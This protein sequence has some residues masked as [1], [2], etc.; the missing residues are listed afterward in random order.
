MA[1]EYRVDNPT[2]QM[3]RLSGGWIRL[4]LIRLLGRFGFREETFVILTACGIGLLTGIGSV[5]FTKLIDCAHDLCY[6]E[7]MVAG[8]YRGRAL[9]LILLPACGALL[10]GLITFFFAREARGHGVP[11]VMDA[12]ARRD[13]VIRPRVAVAKAISSALTIGSGGSAGT[14][15]PIIQ[16]GSAIGSASG[17]FFRVPG[18]HLPVLVGAGAAAGI[19]AIFHAPIAGV[20]FALEVLLRDV[21]FRTFSPVLI[22][23]VLSSVVVSALLGSNQAIFPLLHPD[24]DYSF[25]WIELGNYAILGLLCA[26]A[27]VGFIRLLYRTEDL[28]DG[29]RVHPV[30]KPVIGAIGLGLLGLAIAVLLGEIQAGRAPAIFGNGYPL[31][32][33]CIGALAQQGVDHPFPLMVPILLFLVFAKALATSLTLG[34]GGSG[35]VFAPSL[36][37]GATL[38]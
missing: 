27:A 22:A 23:S 37:L 12:I 2:H 14:E 33:R 21:S 20:L 10:V 30:A 17:Q 7:G 9:F 16:I 25:R 35:G 32:G 4:G 13:G 8:I 15:G 6:G 18:H 11:E 29:L 26:V 24:T 38:G 28:F 36:F 19:S 31:I 34:S 1:S 5:G 3:P